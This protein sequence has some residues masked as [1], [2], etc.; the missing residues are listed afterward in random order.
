MK[1]ICLFFATVFF[2]GALLV[3]CK[4]NDVRKF[5][6]YENAAAY[7]AGDFSCESTLVKRIE[8]DWLGGNVEVEQSTSATVSVLEEE[9]ELPEEKR[10][11]TYLDEGV[12]RVK[13][14]RS[15]C[16]GPIDETQKNLQVDIPKGI[17]VEINSVGANV[18]LGVLELGALSVET[19]AGSIEAESLVCRR[20]DVETNRGHIGM[21]TLR[22]DE[23]EI[24]NF[25]GDIHLGAPLCQSA[26]I[27]TGKGDVTLFLRGDVCAL[28]GFETQKGNLKTDR[29]YEQ[30]DGRYLFGVNDSQNVTQT[31]PTPIFIKTESGDLFVR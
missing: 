8:I 9:N 23:A 29:K 14:C 30:K 28:I 13:Y 7:T 3:G 12:L 26:E 27:E 19:D 10:L 5:R 11:H 18:Y 17:D 25:F 24:E 22:A 6:V 4:A 2:G 20:V 21:G 31:A 1:K 15:G 16:W